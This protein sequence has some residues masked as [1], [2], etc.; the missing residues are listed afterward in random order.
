MK[1]AAV[2]LAILSLGITSVAVWAA[3]QSA[4]AAGQTAPAAGA[5]TAPAAKRPPQA[6]TQPEFDA[7]KA[8]SASTDAAALE[9]ASD[10]FATKFP[11]SELRVL[12]YK[13]AM[14]LYQN[15]NS[16][17]KTEA[18]GR[19]VLSFDAD[20]PEALVIVAEVIAE[21]TRETDIDKDQRY[22][23]GTSMAL[24][25][26]QTVDTDVQVPAG[27]PQDKIDAYK[28]LLRSNAYSILGTIE[29]KK[30]NFPVAQDY[31][32]KS[33][34]AFP[35]NPDPVVIL[36]LALALDKQQKYPEALKAANRAV[37]MTQD[38]TP[39]GTPARRERE[40][41]Q[42]LTGAAVPAPPQA[43]PKN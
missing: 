41:L 22:A 40:R 32:Q 43:P 35:S 33:I 29:F 17:D 27:T 28:A 1:R 24:K 18:M 39:I 26:T 23:E 9:K 7:Y 30:E 16:P 5:T 10:D 13:N 42:Q 4:P 3:A 31:L 37:D 38:N 19:K 15:A 25:A 21:R 36:R 8:A 14:R 20:D 34:D 6:K 11:D 2:I 12:L